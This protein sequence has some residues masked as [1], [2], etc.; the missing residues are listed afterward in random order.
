MGEICM[1]VSI[2]LFTTPADSFRVNG[3]SRRDG[4]VPFDAPWFDDVES[5]ADAPIDTGR[6]VAVLWAALLV[7]FVLE[8]FLPGRLPGFGQFPKPTDWLLIFSTASVLTAGH[9]A[10]NAVPDRDRLENAFRARPLAIASLVYVVLFVLVGSL[11]IFVVGRPSQ[12]LAGA[13]QPPLFTTAPASRVPSCLGAVVNDRCHGTLQYPLGGGPHGQSMLV[14]VAHGASLALKI[15]VVV[16]GIVTPVATAVGVTAGYAGGWTERLLVRLVEFVETLP[17]VL[18]YIVAAFV[19]G[20]SLFLIAVIFSLFS[21]ASAARV[22]RA[23]ATRVSSES[24][25]RSAESAGA[26]DRFVVWKHVVPNV[27]DTVVV[28]ALRGIPAL[29]LAEASLSFL[30]LSD[31]DLFSWGRFIVSGIGPYFPDRFWLWGIPAAALVL[32]VVA[33]DVVGD[34]LRTATQRL[35]E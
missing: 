31:T 27:A 3:D 8:Q 16:L 17:A 29:I 18:V 20:H 13:Y 7:G 24:Y 30:G 1:V 15:S 21:W 25:I 9:A 26:T 5:D 10:L 28:A 11:G 32:T 19:F 2:M 14:L 12:N 35:D 33:L 34:T 23:E 22:V 4:Q 6:I